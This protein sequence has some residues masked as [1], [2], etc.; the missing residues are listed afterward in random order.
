MKLFMFSALKCA[1]GPVIGPK[2]HPA[3]RFR[4]LEAEKYF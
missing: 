2:N 1:I 3:P 4:P